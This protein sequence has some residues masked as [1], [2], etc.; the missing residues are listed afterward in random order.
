M[1]S[2]SAA[3]RVPFSIIEQI[4]VR[5]VYLHR[6]RECDDLHTLAQYA[7][8]HRF[9]WIPSVQRAILHLAPRLALDAAAKVGNVAALERRVA[10]HLEVPSPT[11]TQVLA[12]VD[13]RHLA[14]LEFWLRRGGSVREHL[15]TQAQNLCLTRIEDMLGKLFK[16]MY[17][18][19]GFLNMPGVYRKAVSEGATSVVFRSLFAS[20]DDVAELNQAVLETAASATQHASLDT[21][22]F[23]RCALDLPRGKQ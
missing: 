23:D 4:L 6:G 5:A 8:V 2:I 10:C 16:G 21:V 22:I 15:L 14:L 3:R 13:A 19:D 20:H 18:G 11:I 12:A 1:N 7:R 17:N 9:E